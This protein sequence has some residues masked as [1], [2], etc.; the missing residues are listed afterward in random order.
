[1]RVSSE[2]TKMHSTAVISGNRLGLWTSF[3]ATLEC[4]I[5]RD[6]VF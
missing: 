2:A 6:H 5:L 3:H 4:L 1:M